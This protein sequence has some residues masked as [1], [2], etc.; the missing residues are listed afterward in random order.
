MDYKKEIID[1]LDQISEQKYLKYI[2]DLLK[3]I[4]E[5]EK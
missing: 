3:T 4:L 1:L 2:Y 5:E